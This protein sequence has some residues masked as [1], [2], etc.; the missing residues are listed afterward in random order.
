MQRP[1]TPEMLAAFDRGHYGFADL[2]SIEYPS[3]W[4]RLTTYAH[5]LEDDGKTYRA[6]EG[7][8]TISP[9]L[10]ST[11][12][13]LAPIVAEL[14]ALDPSMVAAALLYDHINRPAVVAV[15]VVESGAVVGVLTAFEGLTN[16]ARMVDGDPYGSAS[17]SV[18]QLSIASEFGDLD[19]KRGRYTN[20]ASQTAIYPGD[21]G[22]RFVHKIA[23]RYLWG[24]A[25]R[26][27]S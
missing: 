5:D 4:V 25:D 7:V 17:E 26:I 18:L 19:Q 11:D 10:E 27:D 13:T 6:A 21:R 14:S 3:G 16:S 12:L 9:A 22:F 23:D 15:A 8:L 1:A 20:D 2:L 24:R